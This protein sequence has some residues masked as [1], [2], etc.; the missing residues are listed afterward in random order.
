MLRATAILSFAIV[1]ALADTVP[2]AGSIAASLENIRGTLEQIS[3]AGDGITSYVFNYIRNGV[4]VQ[5]ES[6]RLRCSRVGNPNLSPRD[7]NIKSVL[8]CHNLATGASVPISPETTLLL[9]A[10]QFANPDTI[11]DLN[12][13]IGKTVWQRLLETQAA[14]MSLSRPFVPVV[15]PGSDILKIFNIPNPFQAIFSRPGRSVQ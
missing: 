11:R 9:S 2:N 8:A 12:L 5:E 10:E 15:V 3:S 7:V 6:V 4:P 13:S 1:T 14:V